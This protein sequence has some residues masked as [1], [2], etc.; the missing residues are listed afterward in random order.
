[1]PTARGWRVG[2]SHKVINVFLTNG[3]PTVD[4]LSVSEQAEGEEEEEE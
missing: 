4:G 2:A 3:E 1:M